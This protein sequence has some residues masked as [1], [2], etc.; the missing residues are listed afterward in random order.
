MIYDVFAQHGPESAIRV[1]KNMMEQAIQRM[2]T[3]I[4]MRGR[5]DLL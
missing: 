2:E 5:D 1:R 4:K 3:E